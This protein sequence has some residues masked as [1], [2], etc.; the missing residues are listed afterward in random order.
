MAADDPSI[1]DTIPDGK[2]LSDLSP[3]DQRELLDR[4]YW[5]DAD[6]GDGDS[7]RDIASRDGVNL[8][9]QGV[10]ERMERLG[11]ERRSNTYDRPDA[12]TLREWHHDELL[13]VA[14]M[15]K[16]VGCDYSTMLRWLH[17]AGIEIIRANVKRDWPACASCNTTGGK[18]S[19]KDAKTP[20]RID[21]SRFEGYDDGDKL[22]KGC[23]NR[24]HARKRRGRDST[25]DEETT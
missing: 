23:Y 14:G 5:G 13:T 24:L 15:A 3:S 22:C 12:D 21:A 19:S 1:D 4:W 2:T 10:A 16:R 8:S 9:P 18:R 7:L 6:D 20:A 17:D 25:D 11:L